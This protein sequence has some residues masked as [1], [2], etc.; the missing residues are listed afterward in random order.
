MYV[1]I[2]LFVFL[3]CYVLTPIVARLAWK[4]GAVDVPLDGRRMHRRSI[5]RD[6]GVAIFAAFLLGLAVLG[7][8]DIFLTCL[9]FGSGVM[10]LV[11]LADDI[12]GLG[13]GAKLLFQVAVATA[14]VF[15][16]GIA[17]GA[18]RFGAILWVVLLT[19]AHN[20][21][22]GMDG[23][24]CGCGAIECLMLGACFFIAGEGI[25]GITSLYL[26]AAC[27]AFR[28]FNRYPAHV[29]AGDS[30]SEALGFALG[31]LSLPLFGKGI[32]L[33]AL[34]PLF[35]FA[36]PIIDLVSTVA[37][38]LLHG[39]NPFRADKAHLHHRVFAAGISHAE[40]TDIF[41]SLS[42]VSGVI[43]VLISTE[44]LWLPAGVLCP[45]AAF[46]LI[47]VKRYV[48]PSQVK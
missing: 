38:R 4:I 11:G 40:C 30:G 1:L 29:F 2:G 36:Y 42:A 12:F 7:E 41:M 48:L 22:D 16:V 31:M 18:W 8:W 35:I 19:N 23:L 25:F 43:G 44:S 34:A 17:E 21:I 3:F 28:I 39:Y 46:F 15:G 24:L 33:S 10:V 45:L 37:R 26:M 14:A 47:S 32:H 5:P 6:G 27:L 13:P 20:F 9:A